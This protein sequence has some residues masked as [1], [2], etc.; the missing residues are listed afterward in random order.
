MSLPI[1][2]IGDLLFV[3]PAGEVSRIVVDPRA[4]W[5]GKV[6]AAG[7][8]RPLPS[9]G[10]IP[11]EVKVGDMVRLKP[12]NAIESVWGQTPIWIV[13]EEDVLA[14]EVS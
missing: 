8:G 13:K 10:C 9:G 4:S 3:E 6:V 5:R 11:L 1:Q 7:P 14:V 12:T 2:P